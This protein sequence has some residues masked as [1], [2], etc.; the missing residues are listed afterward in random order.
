MILTLYIV[1]SLLPALGIEAAPHSDVRSEEYSGKP[2]PCAGF[3][4]GGGM[5]K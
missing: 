1:I 5:P 4:G 2:D 3:V